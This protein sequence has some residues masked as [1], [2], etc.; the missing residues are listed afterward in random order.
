MYNQDS[1]IIIEYS[2]TNTEL[3]RSEIRA[4]LKELCQGT[5]YVPQSRDD[6]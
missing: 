6:S 2:D 1:E 3:S 5:Y 4:F